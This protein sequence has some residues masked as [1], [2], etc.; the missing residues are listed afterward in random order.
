MTQGDKEG[1]P[2]F[3]HYL[4]LLDSARWKSAREKVCACSLDSFRTLLL[5]SVPV[6][7]ADIG[8]F[9]LFIYEVLRLFG[10]TLFF[11]SV[12]KTFAHAKCDGLAQFTFL[13]WCCPSVECV[14]RY[15]T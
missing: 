3:S 15:E 2:D 5:Y 11:G 14:S 8:L 4:E 9:F 12:P 6:T 10:S 7:L 13:D 1:E